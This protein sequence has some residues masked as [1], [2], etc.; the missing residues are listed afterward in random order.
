[1]DLFNGVNL[2][3]AKKAGIP[4]RICHSHNSESQYNASSWKK[5]E[6]DFIEL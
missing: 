1:M 5:S 4:V 6:S 3:V 2:L